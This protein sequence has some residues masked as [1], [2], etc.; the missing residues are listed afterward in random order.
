ML[1][2][3]NYFI[4]SPMGFSVFSKILRIFFFNNQIIKN[5]IKHKIIMVKIN[6]NH[7]V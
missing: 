5:M 1:N 7:K 3:I 6:T 4:L 2:S